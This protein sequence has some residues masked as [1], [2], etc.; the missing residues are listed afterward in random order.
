MPRGRVADA[1]KKGAMFGYWKMI[2]EVEKRNGRRRILCKCTHCEEQTIKE[3]SYTDA[4]KG[5][6]TNCGCVRKQ[7]LSKVKTKHGF[8]KHPLSKVWK[9]MKNR[10]YNTNTKNYN[11]YGGRGITVCKE[12]KDD[13][14]VFA[15]WA[16]ANGYEKGLQID[17]EDNDGNYDPD[18]CRFVTSKVNTNNTS[19]NTKIV[20][21]GKV[22][23]S[24]TIF[25]E[26]FNDGIEYDTA[27][28]RWKKQGFNPYDAVTKPLSDPANSNVIEYKGIIYGS[29]KKF[30]KEHNNG[31]KY[32]TAVKRYREKGMTAIEAVRSIDT[33]TVKALENLGIKLKQLVYKKVQY[34]TLREFCRAVDKNTPYPTVLWRLRQGM[35]PLEAVTGKKKVRFYFA[36]EL[37]AFRKRER[38]VN[39]R[40][41]CSR[42][43]LFT[44]KR[45]S[46]CRLS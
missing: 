2:K 42:T 18:N 6:T 19:R 27:L 22:Y 29:F 43:G 41:R 20:Y 23:E 32:D 10:C 31:T 34:F 45:K 4:K 11:R 26:I 5:N 38:N 14:G 46:I 9:N 8:Y 36:P 21:K 15:T 17:R 39:G 25:W 3:I 16:L 40:D 35:S 1:I 24:F 44:R 37:L 33:R 13:L 7:T 30:W 12:W 28:H